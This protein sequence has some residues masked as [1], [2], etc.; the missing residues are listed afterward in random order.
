MK[1]FKKIV[2]LALLTTTALQAMG[3]DKKRIYK[4]ILFNKE[5]KKET[6][7]LKSLLVNK[8]ISDLLQ[9][10]LMYGNYNKLKMLFYGIGIKLIE[11]NCPV[12]LEK[13]IPLQKLK[14][15]HGICPPCYQEMLKPR[16]LNDGDGSASTLDNK[17]CP[18][19]RAPFES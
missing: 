2:V 5:T 18:I 9:Y 13:Y 19:C 11:G 16:E 14:C 6:K 3:L 4:L 12:C 1:I 17:K 8:P 10:A 7:V 15:N